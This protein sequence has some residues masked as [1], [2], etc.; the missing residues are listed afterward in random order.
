MN[1]KGPLKLKMPDISFK[2]IGRAFSSFWMSYY[3]VVFIVILLLVAGIGVLFWYNAL[4]RSDWSE[5]KK[6][7]FTL[8]QS[9]EI[10]LKEGEF[11]QVLEKVE[12]RKNNYSKEFAPVKDIF[13]P[14]NQPAPEEPAE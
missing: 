14:Y 1:L 6:R 2:K 8:K 4:Y 9:K 13:K 10:N 5:E 3:Q 11:D 12:E 7:E